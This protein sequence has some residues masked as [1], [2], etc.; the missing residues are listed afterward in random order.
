MTMRAVLSVVAEF[1]HVECMAQHKQGYFVFAF[2]HKSRNRG[3]ADADGPPL[4]VR[5]ASELGRAQPMLMRQDH[6]FE[7]RYDSS[8][9]C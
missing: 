9:L 1:C 3:G 2:V 8:A 4:T 6:A 5:P 7:Y